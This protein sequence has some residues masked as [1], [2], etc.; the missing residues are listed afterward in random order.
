MKT[1]FLVFVVFSYF[2]CVANA[3]TAA[4]KK[5]PWD[6]PVKPQTEKWEQLQT[7]K[8]RIAILQIPEDVLSSLSTE[9]LTDV[10]MK[11]PMMT[12]DLFFYR[13]HDRGLDTLIK[14]FNGVRELLKRKDASKELLNWYGRAM[15]NLSFLDGSASDA[16]K[17]NYVL[18]IA[19]ASLLLSRCQLSNDT[20]KENYVEIVQHLIYG[21]EK[22]FAYPKAFNN[23]SFGASSNFYTRAKFITK[24]DK[25]NLDEI[26]LK[27][28]NTLFT[29]AELNDQTIR[30][31]NELSYQIIQKK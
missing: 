23:S 7:V 2:A 21:Y 17:G 1:G 28:K 4:E 15:Q 20:N 6:Y 13:P 10:C 25:K 3:Q 30:A 9:D 12:F 8:E 14:K 31:I 29:S 27:D 18:S 26:P 11:Y 19:A 24:I 5:L 22:L 16:A